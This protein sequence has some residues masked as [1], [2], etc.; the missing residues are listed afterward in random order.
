MKF[1]KNHLMFI[2]PLMA[3]LLGV[4]FYLVFDR[5]TDSYEKGLK[6]GYSMLVITH[7]PESL[8]TFKSLDTHISTSEKIEREGIVSEIAKGVSKDASEE[9]LGA[10]PHFYSVSLDSYLSTRDL[11]KIKSNLEA[12]TN[13]KR[14]ETFGSSY[15]SSYRLFSFIKF[16]LK[17]FIVF[18][19]VVSLFLIIKQM[20]IWKYAHNQRM[21]VMEIFGAPLMLRS[22]ILFKVAILDAILA[23]LFTSLFF[24]YLKFRW[25]GNSGIEMMAQ[26]KESL[27]KMTD[28]AILLAIALFIVIIAVYAV[29]FTAKGERE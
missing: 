25:A 8:E 17:I 14:V 12:H 22:G 23:A 13:V 28:I 20:E 6:E 3:I 21:R 26:N 24:L 19:A 11:N 7:K 2:L 18:M 4:E 5:T 16:S 9:I 15:S 29:V 10:L 27:F 1:I